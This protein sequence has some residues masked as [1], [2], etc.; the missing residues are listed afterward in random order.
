[1]ISGIFA[2]SRLIHRQLR[3]RVAAMAVLCAACLSLGGKLDAQELPSGLEV[4]LSEV[5]IDS[6]PGA[7]RDET[8]LRFRFEMPA[9]DPQSADLVA[10]DAVEADFAVL[11]AET[12][13]PYMAEYELEADKIIISLMSSFVEFGTTAPGTRQM[14]EA[15]LLE[16]G[17][18]I[19]EGF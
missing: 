10:F 1:M 13:L 7:E 16:N 11:C 14:I 17:D 12:A 5:L 9:L 15:F 4:K 3:D 19:W 8:W 18:C 6:V 2:H